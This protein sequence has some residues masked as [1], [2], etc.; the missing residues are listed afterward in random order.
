MSAEL[1]TPAPLDLNGNVSDNWRK[2][3][4]RFRI[5]LQATEKDKKPSALQTAVFLHI[6]GEEAMEV[7][8]T[9]T[10][11]KEADRTDLELVISKFKDYCT[12]KKNVVFER[13]QFFSR[14]QNV[15]EAIDLFVTDLKKKSLTCEFG[16]LRESLI[17]DRIICGLASQ[18]LKE[19]MLRETDL[20][21]EKAIALARADEETKK[22]LKQMTN[23]ASPESVD[24]LHRKYE[25]KK[26][27]DKN[28][29]VTGKDKYQKTDG[30]VQKNCS[31]CGYNHPPRKCPAYGQKCSKCSKMNH[32]SRVCKSIQEI[33]DNASVLSDESDYQI[34]TVIGDENERTWNVN[35]KVNNTNVPFKIDTGADVTVISQS[36]YKKL[37]MPRLCQSTLNLSSPGGNLN[38]VGEFMAK[39]TYKNQR[40]SFKIV[41]V[42]QPLKNN[43]LSRGVSAK[44]GLVK[45][46]DTINKQVFGST[47]LVKT[48][49]VNI[50]LV[51]NAKPYNII[52]P[53]RVPFPIAEAVKEELNRMEK[54]GV[55][56]R[57]TEA[58]DWC[59]PMVPVRKKNGS[60]RICVDFKQLN[61]A[62]KRPH[63]MLPNLEDIAPKLEGSQYFSTLDAS[64]GF[65]QIP[66]DDDSSFLTTFITPFGKY[67]FRR[68]PM[69]IS[70]GP[71]VFQTKMEEILGDLEGCEPLSDD[72]IVFGKTEDEHDQRL[73]KV[74]HKIE[75]SGLRLNREKCVLKK[76]E[77]KYFGHI[78]SKDGIRPN[79]ERVEAILK[80]KEPESV[81]E[82]RT[83]LGMFN[84][85]GRFVP[86]M[87]TILHPLNELLKKESAYFWGSEQQKAFNKIKDMIANASTLAY[88]DVGKETIVSADASSYGLGAVLL[89]RQ[90][91]SLVPIAFASRSLS[92]TERGYAQIEKECLAAVWA[93]EKF[94]Q[95]LVGLPFFQLETDHKPLV[96]IMMTKDLDK[97]PLR[98]Q[99]MLMRMMRFNARVVHK[100][101]KQLLIADALSRFP[102]NENDSSQLQEIIDCYIDHFEE[103][104]SVSPVRLNK[105]RTATVHDT[106]LQQVISYVLH[107][108][109]E[110]VPEHLIKFKREEG[111]FSVRDGLL[112][113]SSRI[114]VPQSQKDEILA[115]L[116]KSHQG[117]NKCR[118]MAQNTVW[119]PGLS[120]DLKKLVN[121]CM[122]C[123]ESRPTQ[124]KEPLKPSVLPSRPWKKLGID[125]MEFKNKPYLIIVDY[126][127]RW[128]EVILLHNTT[129]QT[130]INK[131][132]SVFATHG[133]PDIV[134]CDNGPQFTSKEFKS[135]AKEMDFTVITS[136]PNFAQSNGQAES[137]VK[138]AKKLLSQQN[139]CLALM[140]Y[141]ASPHSSIQIS[142]A[143]ALMGRKIRTQVPILESQ[144]QPKEIPHETIRYADQKSKLTSKAYY[145][146]HNGAKTP[147]TDLSPGDPV[148]LQ[149]DQTSKWSAPGTV[150]ATDHPHR[151]YLVNTPSGVFRRNRQQ[152]LKAPTTNHFLPEPSDEQDD[153]KN[154]LAPNPNNPDSNIIKTPPSPL[155]YQPNTRS[156]RGFIAA[157]PARFREEE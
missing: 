62:V 121:N 31:R 50:K 47:G 135:F 53:R 145:D 25:T 103:D 150:V 125:L 94:S 78:I 12:P 58:T 37:K 27:F 93:C 79:K 68:V 88:Y 131:L 90:K 45:R 75:K 129:S 115:K 146:R 8:N 138:I 60:V 36:T 40:Y 67:R 69:G 114:V 11:D 26:K 133:L 137:G 52:T 101:G 107:G 104:I 17:R 74:L 23:T 42:D 140:N 108:W 136:S 91:S 96:P 61:A 38:T 141:R 99:R 73:E 98:C 2:F 77:V 20:T 70:L 126:Y 154:I 130:V 100:P 35:L 85:L 48:K 89:Q 5:Y 117:I 123:Q 32:Y 18:H 9:F 72:T 120:C 112:I 19:R 22:Q 97:T 43:L 81:S 7:Y 128:L 92:K 41:V 116:H 57:T 142:P 122:F 16:D 4:Q 102:T 87:A 14:T 28:T 124:K 113:M 118:K 144:L 44:L 66:L 64:G 111:N 51:E 29:N 39:T 65:F 148:L 153:A 119:W 106:D 95:Y 84:Y 127:S 63:C 105:I 33:E 155:S 15:G 6:A 21:L 34:D 134:R 80:L 157:K 156:K 86:N 147:L 54:N 30:K 71:E 149:S 83:V 110:K 152:L 49:P 151:T 24:N 139:F 143:E 13:H 10:F 3:I 109:P 56:Q 59:A 46:I 76:K 82:L 132:G 1:S 55:I